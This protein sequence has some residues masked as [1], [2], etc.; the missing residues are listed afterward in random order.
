MALDPDPPITLVKARILE[1]YGST[2]EKSMM[3]INQL[4]DEWHGVISGLL[5]RSGLDA[6]DGSH[7]PAIACQNYGVSFALS[8]SVNEMDRLLPPALFRDSQAI[9]GQYT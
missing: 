1:K 8:M 6:V 7:A 4:S 9:S 3:V 5:V 2:P